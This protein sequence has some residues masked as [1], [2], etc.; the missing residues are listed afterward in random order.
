MK[1]LVTRPRPD[2]EGQAEKLKGFGHQA[3][4][5]PLLRIEFTKAGELKFDGLQALIATSRNALRAMSGRKELA[6]AVK[7]P[8]FA[9]SGATADLAR[10]LGFTRIHTG[11]GTAERLVPLVTDKLFPDKGPLMHL[12]GESL[13]FDLKGALE[14]EGFR[15]EQPVLYRAAPAETFSGEALS[16]FGSGQLDGVILMSP[17]TARTYAALILKKDLAA[18]AASLVHYC[19]SSNVARGLVSLPETRLAVADKPSE[20]DL[21]A[22]IGRETAN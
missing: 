15:L 18:N 2:A 16:A 12:A 21:L 8:L 1:I 6:Q 14:E 11:S 13:A 7:L 10:D 5:S 20:D 9:V 17:A 4:I 22:L 3:V 19:L